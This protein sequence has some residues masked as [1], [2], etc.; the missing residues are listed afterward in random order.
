M[1]EALSLAELENK[2]RKLLVRKESLEK[3]LLLLTTQLLDTQL[4]ISTAKKRAD[5]TP[6]EQDPEL[7]V[8]KGDQ[9][10]SKDRILAWLAD[11]KA[12]QL[13]A[14]MGV[15]GSGKSTLVKNLIKSKELSKYEVHLTATTNKAAATL[16][17]ITGSQVKTIHSL[18]GLTMDEDGEEVKL[19]APDKEVIF[20]S[21]ELIVVDEGSMA[22]TELTKYIMATR[23]KVLIIGDNYQLPPVGELKSPLFKLCRDNDS[24]VMMRQVLRFDS[25]LINLS[26]DLRN[27]ITSKNYIS[28]I[29]TMGEQVTLFDSKDDFYAELLSDLSVNKFKQT[30]IIAWR[31]KTVDEYN[32]LVRNELGF[33]REFEL[34]ESLFSASPIYDDADNLIG[35]V[36][37]DLFVENIEVVQR[38]ISMPGLAETSIES[39]KLTVSGGYKGAVY[40]ARDKTGFSRYS[41]YLANL[42]KNSSGFGK[43]EA[44]KKFWKF[45]HSFVSVRYGY[46]MTAHRSQG[47]SYDSVFVDQRDILVNKDKVTAFKCLYVACTRPR[48]RLYSF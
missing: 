16:S 14:F 43:S 29:R 27:C 33:S 25:D 18:L 15:A 11:P 5:E 6:E 3:E 32:Y 47:S 13:F 30:K 28:P 40:V 48:R 7:L 2:E 45:K 24:Y 23:A 9:P 46:A 21:R 1:L 41:N 44:W 35:S 42:A 34:G 37:T 10:K 17:E 20:S 31:N 38:I 8:L 26:V 36:D 22:N 4:A 19:K 39:Y 12:Y